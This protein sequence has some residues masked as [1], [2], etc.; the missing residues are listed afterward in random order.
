MLHI[1]DREKGDKSEG[2][3][4]SRVGATAACDSRSTRWTEVQPLS[5]K[6]LIRS[7]AGKVQQLHR[8]SSSAVVYDVPVIS[9]SL[10]MTA[11]C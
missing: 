3:M 4:M 7:S 5:S 1:T 11:T 6:C 8:S 2:Y 10:F 9:T